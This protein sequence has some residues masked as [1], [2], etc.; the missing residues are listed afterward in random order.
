MEK[1]CR[2]AC[3]RRKKTVLPASRPSDLS[4]RIIPDKALAP[5]PG[6]EPLSTADPLKQNGI[7]YRNAV[8]SGAAD[9]SL[10]IW[11]GISFQ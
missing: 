4:G 10:K 2:V 9:Q 1:P 11:C 6:A 3:V 7:P 8:L 5:L